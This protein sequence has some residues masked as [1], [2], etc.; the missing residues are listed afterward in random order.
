[1]SLQKCKN[2]LTQASEEAFKVMDSVNSQNLLPNTVAELMLFFDNLQ[3][4]FL[5]SV[6][7]IDVEYWQASCFKYGL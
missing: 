5:Q 6:M 3:A 7:G 1:M 2:L 4:D